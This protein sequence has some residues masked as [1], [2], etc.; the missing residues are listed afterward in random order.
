MAKASKRAMIRR[1]VTGLAFTAC[2]H[3][4]FLAAA[5][6]AIPTEATADKVLAVPAKE[7]PQG[8][9]FKLNVGASGSYGES[10]NVVGTADGATVQVGLFLNG[11][12]NLVEDQNSWENTLKI[13]ETETRTPQVEGFFKSAD[14]LSL[15]STYLYRLPGL[16]WFGPYA[17]AAATTELFDSYAVWNTDVSIVRTSRNGATQTSAIPASHRVHLATTFDPT[18]VKEGVG[19]F[20]NPF[21]SKDFTIKTKAGV[22]TQH[23]ITRNGFV[24]ADNKNTPEIEF[25]QLQNST[26]AGG[27]VEVAMSGQVS[28]EVTWTA[29]ADF[30]Y[31]FYTSVQS[32][33][34]GIDRMSTDLSAKVSVRLAKWVSLDY[35]LSVKR[36]PL[37]LDLWQ[38]QNNVLLTAGFE[39]L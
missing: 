34:E 21:A 26:Q 15:Q 5:Q 32:K 23:V 37:I 35:V 33:L 2:L 25:Q 8:W 28:D 11:S 4:S 12:V 27:E 3:I 1:I 36:L 24:L 20:A 18:L 13:K 38:V 22:A 39:L 30:F 31:P 29:K 6:Q 7:V 17:R 14:E 16:D 19:A 9:A 10:S